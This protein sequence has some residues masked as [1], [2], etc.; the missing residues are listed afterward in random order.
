MPSL[1]IKTH[2]AS[3]W[4]HM[5]GQFGEF[6]DICVNYTLKNVLHLILG[7]IFGVWASYFDFQKVNVI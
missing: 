6:H 1:T 5:G 3:R 7:F 4:K 2:G